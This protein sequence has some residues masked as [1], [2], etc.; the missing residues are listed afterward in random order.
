[1][2]AT[3]TQL[4]PSGWS[5][6]GRAAVAVFGL[7]MFYVQSVYFTG[8]YI[9]EEEY[10]FPFWTGMTVGDR[11]LSLVLALAANVGLIMAPFLRAPG[12]AVRFLLIGSLISGAAV[13]LAWL[14]QSLADWVNTATEYPDRFM[15]ILLALAPSTT[16]F[17]KIYGVHV[18]LFLGFAYRLI[19]TRTD[20]N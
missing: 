17:Y 6:K 18:Y 14:G 9:P 10:W 1:M 3:R 7:F 20:K 15:K 11:L 4:W 5:R 19:S 16:A 8:F 13:S 12:G 2:D